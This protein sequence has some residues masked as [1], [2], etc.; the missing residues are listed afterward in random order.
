MID[1]SAFNDNTLPPPNLGFIS[2]TYIPVLFLIY[3]TQYIPTMSSLVFNLQQTSCYS[4]DISSTSACILR[5]DSITFRFLLT[6]ATIPEVLS[7]RIS[8]V[9]SCPAIKS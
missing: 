9:Y 1:G 7:D 8:T 5:P 3:W 4:S 2:N 6:I